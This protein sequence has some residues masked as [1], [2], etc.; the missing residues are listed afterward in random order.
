[1]AVTV[2]AA[3]LIVTNTNDSG[4]GSLRDAII[5]AN[6][7]DTIDATG[8]SGTILLTGG[9]L[10][11]THSVTIIGPG[12]GNLAVNG[13]ATFRV[14]HNEGSNTTISGLTITNGVS[15][16]GLGGGGI[17]NNGGLTV[18]DTSIVNNDGDQ[19]GG[20]IYSTFGALPQTLTVMNSTI[21]NNVPGGIEVCC[22]YETLTVMN[23]TISN[24]VS[25]SSMGGVYIHGVGPLTLT[26]TNSTISGNQNSF[27]G[28]GI[29]AGDATVTVTNST[30]SGNTGGCAGGGIYANETQ[31]TVKNSTISGNSSPQGVCSPGSGLGGGIYSIG[32]NGTLTVTDSTISDNSATAAGGGIWNGHQVT[33]LIV[34]NST[35]NGNSA[36]TGGTI[37]NNGGGTV[38]MGNTILNAGASG[39]TIESVGPFTSLGYNLASDDGG[40][41]LTSPGDQ[42]NTNPMLGPLQDNG[43]P[44]FTHALLHG[45]PAINAGDPNFTP[46]PS[47]DQRGP[48]FPRVFRGRIDIGSFEVQRHR[49]P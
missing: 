12:A 33:S 29:A 28:G 13:N 3:T 36:P 16:F 40:G 18:I 10:F 5:N 9:E 17:L 22:A 41:V 48:G 49:T 32:F 15:E 30:I 4:P 31:L 19:D 21:S 44:T 38:Q 25:D 7:G 42:I 11:N 23:S 24:N 14:F 26:V 37:W 45:S 39:G 6:D 2:H 20:G 43:G 27:G 46:P 1:M 35:F 47:H 8:V 34:K